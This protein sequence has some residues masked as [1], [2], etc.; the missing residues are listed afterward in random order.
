MLTSL[1]RCALVALLFTACAPPDEAAVESPAVEVTVDPNSPY[2]VLRDR[3][4]FN[5]PSH[6]TFDHAEPFSHMARRWHAYPFTLYRAAEIGARLAV[7]DA[8]MRGEAAI[9]LFGPAKGDGRWPQ[10]RTLVTDATGVAVMPHEELPP[11]RYLYVVGP[12]KAEGF[13]ARYPSD[14]GIGKWS[15]GGES[16]PQYFNKNGDGWGTWRGNDWYD[17]VAPLPGRDAEHDPQPG[18]VFQLEDPR[19]QRLS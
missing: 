16:G 17:V 15:D 19:G 14:I 7:G 8:A 10:P 4:I 6:Q 13:A 9:W 11:G 3:V 12:R 18:A 5:G 1:R 2:V